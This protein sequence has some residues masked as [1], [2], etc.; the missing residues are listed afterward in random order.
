[1]M[2]ITVKSEWVVQLSLKTGDFWPSWQPYTKG[3]RNLWVPQHTGRHPRS[4][5]VGREFAEVS[6]SSKKTWPI[7]SDTACRVNYGINLASLHSF[8]TDCRALQLCKDVQY[9]TIRTVKVSPLVAQSF[10]EWQFVVTISSFH[11]MKYAR[12]GLVDSDTRRN[13]TVTHGRRCRLSGLRAPARRRRCR[14]VSTS[15]A[16]TSDVSTGV[17]ADVVGRWSSASVPAIT[18]VTIGPPRHSVASAVDAGDARRRHRRLMIDSRH[19]IR[20]RRT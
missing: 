10:R 15:T 9:I 18:A 1:M 8:V 2:M 20:R 3:S 6:F 4:I 13:W 12:P 19:A 11:K 16:P 5:H 14:R 7:Y 17:Q